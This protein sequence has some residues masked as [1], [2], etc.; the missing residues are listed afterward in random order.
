MSVTRLYKKD[1]I[2]AARSGNPGQISRYFPRALY[3]KEK[4]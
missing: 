3:K 1:N 4:E 2:A